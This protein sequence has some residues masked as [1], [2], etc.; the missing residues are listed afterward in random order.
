MDYD[1][2]KDAQSGDRKAIEGLF[3][4]Y[5]PFIGKKY[6]AACKSCGGFSAEYELNDFMSEGYIAYLKALKYTN[7][8]KITDKENWKFLGV[9]MWF[10]TTM[11]NSMVHK[12]LKRSGDL[13]IYTPDTTNTE[14]PLSEK[15]LT[16]PGISL[17]EEV[18][19][20]DVVERFYQTLTPYES[21]LILRR[22]DLDEKGYPYPIAKIAKERGEPF[23]RVQHA[24]K[25]LE[26]RFFRMVEAG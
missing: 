20:K 8:A 24:C 5:R 11:K 4:Q 12:L 14:D 2:V 19:Q 26:E 16:Y 3:N 6:F 13:P 10:I 1:L 22:T 25:E 23:S 15:E 21:E 18:C 7:L 17:E 9:L